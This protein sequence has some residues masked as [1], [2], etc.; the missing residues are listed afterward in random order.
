MYPARILVIAA[1]LP[2][3]AALAQPVKAPPLPPGSNLVRIEPGLNPE[4]KKRHVRAH[5]HKGHVKK[6]MTRDDS[7]KG[8]KK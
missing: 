5:H 6:D 8:A 2:T 4:E 7:D 3:A 1:L